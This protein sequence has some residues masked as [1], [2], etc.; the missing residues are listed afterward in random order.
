M[1]ERLPTMYKAVGLIPASPKLSKIKIIKIIN[2]TSKLHLSQQNIY[3]GFWDNITCSPG[4]SWT[5]SVAKDDSELWILLL[6][7]PTCLDYTHLLPRFIYV[8][9]GTEFRALFG[10][11]KR[12]TNSTTY[13]Q[14]LKSFS[15]RLNLKGKQN[16]K[17]QRQSRILG[18]G[19]K[20]K[21]WH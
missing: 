8:M 13:V 10:L 12:S 19:W 17:C 6:L 11:G 5:F 7:H 14:L 4:W 18:W 20:H 1:V 9:L 15:T 16:A 21:L 3:L 2:Q